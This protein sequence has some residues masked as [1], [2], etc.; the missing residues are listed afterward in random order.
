MAAEGTV[1]IMME[2]SAAIMGRQH[3]VHCTRTN[4]LICNWGREEDDVCLH[5][6]VCYIQEGMEQKE[7]IDIIVTSKTCLCLPFYMLLSVMICLGLYPD[8]H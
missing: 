2:I 6:G 8:I 5:V 7:G 4:G 1:M 3:R